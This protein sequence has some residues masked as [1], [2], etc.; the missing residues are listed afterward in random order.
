VRISN[1]HAFALSSPYGSGNAGDQVAFFLDPYASSGSGR[2]HPGGVRLQGIS[3]TPTGLV[4]WF[5]QNPWL[6]VTAPRTVELGTPV[7]TAKTIDVDLSAKA[8][9]EEPQCPAACISYLAFRGPGYEFPYGTARGAP[10][11]LYFAEIRIGTQVHTLAIA[12]DSASKRTFRQVLPAATAIVESLRVD[13]VPVAELSQ[14]SAICTKVFAGT[15]LGEVTA[16]THS[17]STFEP[18]LTYTVPVGWTNYGDTRGGVAFV[19]PG[20]DWRAVDQNKSDYVNVLPQIAPPRSN[21]S[22]QPSSV[23]SPKGFLGWLER[24]PG[25]DV[26]HTSRVSLGGLSGYVAD[27]RMRTD[28]KRTCPWSHGAPAILAIIGVPPTSKELAHNVT[29]QPMV[30]RLY[31]LAYNGGTLGIEIDE[32][33]G[34][35]KLAAYDKVVRSFRFARA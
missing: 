5:R 18:K 3:R 12:F 1:D 16:G 2:K 23:R 32:V 34:D 11:R 7:L 33:A 35:E 22:D 6:V 17:T 29:P 8:P 15:C 27:L 30:M 10:A 13:A 26:T 14:F 4:T 19:P 25:L 31:L 20:G 28:W 21:C 9:K 24:N